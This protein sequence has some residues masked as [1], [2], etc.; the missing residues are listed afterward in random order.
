MWE[1][2]WRESFLL[3]SIISSTDAAAVFSI[4]RSSNLNLRP[5]VRALLE[6]ESGSNDPVAVF[7]TVGLLSSI[8]GDLDVIAFFLSFLRQMILGAALG[9][10]LGKL[11]A[12]VLKKIRL[13]YEGLYPVLTLSLIFLVYGLAAAVGGNGFLAVYV[14]A[15]TLGSSSFLH[16]R[17]LI[18]FHDGLAWLLQIVMFVALGLL[19][20]PSRLPA[21]A[22]GG[23]AFTVFLMLVARPAGVFLALS[24]SKMPFREKF[25]LAWAGLRGAVPI[26]LAT[27]PL[28]AGLP[29]AD[30]FFHLIFF[31]VIGSSLIQGGTMPWLARRL[32]IEETTPPH[33]RYPLEFEPGEGVDTE[34]VEYI[35]PYESG[36]AGK[37]IVELGLPSDSLVTLVCREGNYVVPA[38]DTVLQGGDVLLTLVNERNART[39]DA[40][41]KRPSVS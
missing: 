25:F 27:F 17:S 9:Y 24:L 26:V 34:L 30:L 38:G 22:L 23:L 16:K 36:I 3:G 10:G 12:F 4:L 29:K 13:E 37:K 11:S 7:L 5:N 41:L 35:V 14:A 15:L 31:I 28:V 18:R 19:V 2:N 8:T 20:F 40:I 21:V 6:F 32:G 1:L 39:V 33:G